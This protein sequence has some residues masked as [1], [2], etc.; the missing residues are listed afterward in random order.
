MH[1]VMEQRS[2]QLVQ[3]FKLFATTVIVTRREV[4]QKV[5]NC[6]KFPKIDDFK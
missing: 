5:K 4:K 1:E 3:L 2:L 6:E